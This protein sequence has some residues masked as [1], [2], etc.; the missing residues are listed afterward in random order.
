MSTRPTRRSA[1]LRSRRQ[2]GSALVFGLVF[3]I[4]LSVLSVSYLSSSALEERMAGGSQ[5]YNI[6]LQ[7]AESAL[8]DAEQDLIN[9]LT[10][11]DV[12]D[13]SCDAGLCLPTTSGGGV[14]TL[15]SVWSNARTYGEYTGNTPLQGVAAQPVYILERLGGLPPAPGSS[16]RPCCT[17]PGGTAYRVTAI[18]YGARQRFPLLTPQSKVMLQAVVRK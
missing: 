11:S 1:R 14:W 18:G 17:G 16:L 13:A 8:R 9:V 5:D 15:A 2:A 10:P 3:L 4:A 12:F 7:A 6:A